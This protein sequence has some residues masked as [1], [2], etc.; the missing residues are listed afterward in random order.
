MKCLPQSSITLDIIYDYCIS[1]KYK[2]HLWGKC[3]KKWS[4]ALMQI[5]NLKYL[6]AV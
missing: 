4:Y 2:A 1:E 3:N 6:Q 5:N